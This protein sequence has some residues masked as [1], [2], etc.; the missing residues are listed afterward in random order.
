MYLDSDSKLVINQSIYDM[1]MGT[2]I[3]EA[4]PLPYGDFVFRIMNITSFT[5]TTSIYELFPL[6]Y[7]GSVFKNTNNTSLATNAI[8]N[9]HWIASDNRILHISNVKVTSYCPQNGS[10]TQCSITMRNDDK[11]PNYIYTN[12]ATMV[13]WDTQQNSTLSPGAEITISMQTPLT[14][15]NDWCLIWVMEKDDHFF[16]RKCANM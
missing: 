4:F 2:I 9:P 15:Y 11:V 10:T 14:G 8:Q 1:P 3:Y 6:H 12:L 7:G 13:S 16:A 5:T